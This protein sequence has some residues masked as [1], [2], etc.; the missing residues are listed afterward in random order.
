MAKAAIADRAGDPD[1]LEQHHDE[2]ARDDQDD[3]LAE[4]HRQRLQG[5]AERRVAEP[6]QDHQAGLARAE[7]IGLLA[8]R[9]RARRLARDQPGRRHHQR[10]EQQRDREDRARAEGPREPPAQV[11]HADRAREQGHAAERL[12]LLDLLLGAGELHGERVRDHVLD[13]EAHRDDH[14]RGQVGGLGRGGGGEPPVAREGQQGAEQQVGD[15]A[16]TEDGVHVGGHAGH[17]LRAPRQG[18]PEGDG[19]GLGRRD[20]ER[21]L[22]EVEQ[23]DARDPARPVAEVRDEHREVGQAHAP[24][25]AAQD[26]AARGRGRGRGLDRLRHHGLGHAAQF[27]AL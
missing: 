7:R 24:E 10:G 18:D 14:H 3:L 2:D 26:R 5:D 16:A 15:P 11:A 19:G 23:R 21:V 6:H 22:L 20:A 27:S 1:A 8:G 9:H 17:H 25:E 13:H 12:D 4:R